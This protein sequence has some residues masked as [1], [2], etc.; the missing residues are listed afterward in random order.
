MEKVAIRHI[1]QKKATG[2]KITML[3]AYD[4]FMAK[5]VDEAGIDAILIGDSLGMVILG[6]QSTTQVTM[7]DMIRHAMAVRRGAKR[8]L[9]IG[10]MPYKS[11]DTSDKA[12]ANARRFIKE[13]G[14]DAVK[15]EGE[16][17][18]A[19]SAII[20]DGIPVLGHL[21]L[22]PQTAS[23]FKVQGKDAESAKGILNASLGLEGTGCFA[24]V[25]ECVPAKL[26]AT[27]TSKLSIPTIGIG[28]GPQ[29]DGQVLVLN[30][31]LGLFDRFAPRFVKRYADLGDA[32]KKAIAAFK[33]DVE[34]GKF[35][36]SEHSFKMK[37]EE[38]EKL[39]CE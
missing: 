26:A 39:K 5:L 21:G 25:L 35:P 22:T 1:Q 3:T 24:I 31:I 2:K 9:I 17:R 20:K 15:L 19:A 32:A 12:V 27:I 30:D 18:R 16:S 28:A 10:D 38:L 29:C 33:D 34:T 13:A 11:F 6:Y 4:Y 8:A 23:E 37:K 7:N 14:C 36:G